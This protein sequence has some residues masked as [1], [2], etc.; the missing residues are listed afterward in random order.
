MPTRRLSPSRRAF[1]LVELLV[2]IAIIAVLMALLVP[3]VQ[4]AREAARRMQCQGNLRQLA[5]ACRSYATR[6]GENPALPPTGNDSFPRMGDPNVVPS[7]GWLYAI[8]PFVEQQPLSDL[9]LGLTGTALNAAITTRVGTPLSLYVCPNRGP[10]LFDT[11]AVAFQTG[12]GTNIN[13][14]PPR[15][16]RSDYAGCYSARGIRVTGGGQGALDYWD[17][18]SQAPRQLRSITDGAAN[19]FLCGER[20]LDPDQYR[21]PASVNAECNNRGWSA[22][23]EG[24]VYSTVSEA[25]GTPIP[26]LSDTIG[27]SRCTTDSRLPGTFGGPHVVQYMA[28]VDGA[29][30]AVGFEIDPAIFKALGNISDGRGTVDDLQ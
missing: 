13:P 16:A 20:Y 9:G 25:N 22:P 8:L 30:R 17:Y 24:D 28:M 15:A 4:S 11:P 23:A 7:G 21:P 2:V 6:Q 3:A 26:P 5:L 18:S 27:V 12:N 1:T 29:V 10:A 19:V 14:R